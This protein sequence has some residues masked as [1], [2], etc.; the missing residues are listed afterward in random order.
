[1]A[2]IPPAVGL[3]TSWRV[4]LPEFEGPLDLL[5]QLIKVNEVEITDIPVAIV[6]HQFHEYIDLMDELDL[7]IAAE[8]V[9]TAAL[10]I[11]LKSKMLLPQPKNLD[12][13]QDEQDP[14]ADLVR[15]LLEYQRMKD[16]A[17]TLSEVDTVRSAMWS[18]GAH[19]KLQPGD[20]DAFEDVSLYDL[21]KSLREVLDRYSTEHPPPIHLAGETYSVRGQ[22]EGFLSRLSKSRPRQLLDELASLS[23]RAEAIAAFL[24]I[25]EMA[26][27]SLVRVHQTSN[28]DIL[29][30]RTT[31][32][33]S[34][35]ELET[36]EG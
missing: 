19:E 17:Q 6:C 30:Y 12:G 3:P 11:H 33:L 8:F 5:L 36:I 27:L 25:L 24:A 29:L 22:I 16:V 13:T 26:R 4:E 1:M 32:E 23:C 18:R 21:M 7:D 15:R 35:R 2:T 9:Y 14:R 34:P 10:L 20:D 28:G 31:K